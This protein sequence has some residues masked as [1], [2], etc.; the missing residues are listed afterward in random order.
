[1]K[2]VNQHNRKFLLD[3]NLVSQYFEGVIS[4]RSITK[5][6]KLLNDSKKSDEKKSRKSDDN[7]DMKIDE[8]SEKR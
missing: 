7:N 8:K 5:M 2:G 1:V 6:H 3:F 4:L